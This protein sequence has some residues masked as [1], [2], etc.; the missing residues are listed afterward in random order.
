VTQYAKLERLLTRKRGCTAMDIATEVGSTSP[1]KRVSELR[2]RGWHITK[3]QVP[4]KSYCVYRG[5]RP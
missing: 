2:A 4:G 3:N 5:V 1:H